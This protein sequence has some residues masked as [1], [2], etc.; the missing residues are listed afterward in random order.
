MQFLKVFQ[1]NILLEFSLVFLLQINQDELF[2]KAIG[3][4]KFLIKMID[5][6]KIIIARKSNQVL[7]PFFL[8]FYKIVL[9]HFQ[10]SS[11]I[12]LIFNHILC[13][14]NSL[15]LFIIDSCSEYPNG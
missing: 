13:C 4:I 5:Y 12:F 9:R 11:G 3:N 8:L 6:Q 14:L 7:F 15:S 10:D 1:S 2:F